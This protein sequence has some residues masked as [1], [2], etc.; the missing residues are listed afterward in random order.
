MTCTKLCS[1]VDKH[2][3]HVGLMFPTCMRDPSPLKLDIS[4]APTLLINSQDYTFAIKTLGR[5][6]LCWIL[7]LKPNGVA[8][9][10]R[11]GSCLVTVLI[12][13][14]RGRPGAQFRPKSIG[15]WV[16]SASLDHP[17]VHGPHGSS[18]QCDPFQC[19]HFGL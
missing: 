9:N 10:Q 8:K 19:G 3:K 5:K 17:G 12:I 15:P 1:H 11:V 6:G 18:A 2:D 14:F 16:R 4:A 13:K 7:R